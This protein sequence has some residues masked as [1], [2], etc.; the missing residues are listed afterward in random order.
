MKELLTEIFNI[1][2]GRFRKKDG[3]EV[4][5][6]YIDPTSSETTYPYKDEIKKYGAVWLN[7]LKT[8]GWFT[9]GNEDVYQTKIKPCLEYLTSVE[10]NPDNESRDVVAMIDKLINEIDNG[11]VV[12]GSE[13]FNV[14][15]VKRRLETFKRELM[16]V[17]SNEEFKAKMLPIIKFRQAQG[18]QF[19]L[20]NAILIL[21]QD[22]KATLVKSK[23]NWAKMNRMVKLGAKAIA[24]WV[25]IGGTPLS[26]GQ[27]NAIKDRFLASRNVESVKDL[28]PGDKEELRVQL[29]PRGTG[30]KL[31]PSFFDV[32][33]TEQMEGKED[34]VGNRTNDLPWFD[35]K[36]EVT[37][38]TT[39]YCDAIIEI[40]QERGIKVS[41]VDDLGGARGVSKSGAIDVLKDAPKNSGLFNTLVHEYAHEL[42]H[43][44]YIKAKDTNPTGYGQYF[45]GT[46]QGRS[47]VEQQAELTAWIVLRNFGFDMETNIN[48]VGMW[49]MDEKAAP[50]VFDTVAK[51]ATAI[52]ADISDKVS[53]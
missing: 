41:F 3:T 7:S 8:W 2:N 51:V 52:I 33:F 24:L 20:L 29:K 39:Q 46:S 40:I 14:E 32:R 23:S 12:S 43:Q 37:E 44:K 28:N 49:G 1:K 42:L 26:Q 45:I 15:D 16:N 21:I 17:M 11:N 10:Q 47:V 9:N 34:L 48:Y 13:A 35:D 4:P 38:E 19:S 6:A 31:V 50:L 30:F 36:G 22:R 53:I 5:I 25:P 27:K 18:H